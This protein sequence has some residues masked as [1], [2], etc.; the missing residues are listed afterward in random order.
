MTVNLVPGKAGGGK[1]P[2]WKQWGQQHTVTYLSDVLTEICARGQPEHAGRQLV[3]FGCSLFSGGF[4]GKKVCPQDLKNLLLLAISC[5]SLG[6]M[7]RKRKCRYIYIFNFSKTWPNQKRKVF[8]IFDTVFHLFPWVNSW[9]S[10]IHSVPWRAQPTRLGK[11]WAQQDAPLTRHPPWPSPWRTCGL[12]VAC[13]ALG[14]PRS[15]VHCLPGP[16]DSTCVC[17]MV[18][19]RSLLPSIQNLVF[20]WVHSISFCE[21]MSIKSGRGEFWPSK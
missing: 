3:H 9:N 16:R 20:T 11:W 10:L 12:P 1:L 2:G 4:A 19:E 5:Q 7:G 8:F 15:L 21:N 18:V 6:K 17:P 14:G 13:F